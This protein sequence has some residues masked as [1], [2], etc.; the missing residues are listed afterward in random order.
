M[1]R[2]LSSNASNQKDSNINKPIELYQVYLDEETLYLA[3][4][5]DAIDFFDE[6]GNPTTYHGAAISRGD[7]K[8]NVDTK[9]N[10]CDVTIGNVNKEMSAY[11]A[12][13]EFRKRRLVIWKVFQD[14]LSSVDDAIKMFDGV[15]DEPRIAEHGLSITV[16]DRLNVFQKKVP[17]RL[18]QLQC[19]WLFGEEG[20][21]K[22]V[23]TSTALT[24]DSI[25]SDGLTVNSAEITEDAGYW[26]FGSFT[27]GSIDRVIDSSA[28]GSVTLDYPLPA[29]IEAGASFD[30]KAGCDKTY[31]G[32]HGCT[33]WS[34]TD[35]YGGFRSLPVIESVREFG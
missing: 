15:M 32:G 8:T 3:R 10:T 2:D 27:S 24:I 19:P 9:V 31:N 21:F 34:N 12:A 33:Y 28:T 30:L 26:S 29:S 4:H 22:T 16:T 1:P 23:P 25:S 6:A 11:I 17:T 14:A 13:T 5:H 20:C 18:Y 7:I 35:Q